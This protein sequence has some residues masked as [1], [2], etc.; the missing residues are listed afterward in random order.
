[1]IKF[2][3]YRQ[4]DSMDC[5]PTCV[6]IIAAYY[7][8][9]YSLQNLRDKCRIDREGVSMLGISEASEQ[10]GFRTVAVKLSI[11]KL[12]HEV[13]LPCI[14]HWRQNH[15]VVLYK[16]KRGNFFVSDPAKGLVKLSNED[17]VKGWIS[18]K[19]NNNEQGIALLLEPGLNFQ[20][21]EET[22]KKGISYKKLASTF[23]KHKRLFIQLFLGLLTGSIL[24]LLV[25]FL[26]QSVV[27]Q[28][29]A[30]KDLNFITLVLFGQVMLFLGSTVLDF[31]R[32]WILLHI[33]AR[34]N[35]SLLS[36]FLI[37]LLHLPISFFDSKK[38]ADIIQRMGDH[39]R[40]ENYLSVSTMSTLFSVINFI[41]YG[42]LI[43]L[44]NV[45]YM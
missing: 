30:T 11:E 4:Y 5:G 29:I 38:T 41:L 36:E 34:I 35:L 6:R 7:G 16:I 9:Y 15:F 43:V 31:I 44:Y 12:I 33:S 10:I 3:S 27:D 37:K 1:M 32:S 20:H 45:P 22:G 26:T 28:G 18:T 39:S 23:L 17:F 2:P 21:I 25:P 14:V 40:I 24:Q 13:N 8:K 42:V 19:N